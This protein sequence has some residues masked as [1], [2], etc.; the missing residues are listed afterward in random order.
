MCG[1]DSA[2]SPNCGCSYNPLDT[3]A[4]PTSSCEAPTNGAC[5]VDPEVG[6]CLCSAAKCNGFIQ[7]ASCNADAVRC[8]PRETEVTSCAGPVSGGTCVNKQGG[9]DMA[10]CVHDSDCLSNFCD[11]TGHP[12]PYC[13]VPQP[14]DIAAGRGLTC[15]TD[16]SCEAAQPGFSGVGKCH[17][18][19]TDIY[20]GC[21]FYCP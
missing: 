7:V 19:G 13:H 17:T 15:S 5:C 21:E 12:G 6:Q 1:K 9:T 11:E 18:G 20:E 2:S 16:A 3:Y 8:L 4:V 10:P 14:Q